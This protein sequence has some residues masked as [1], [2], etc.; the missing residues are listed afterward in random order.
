MKKL[1][2]IVTPCF[3]EED[4]IKELYLRICSAIEPYSDYD[5]EIIAI[6]NASTDSTVEV[7]KELAYN[8]KRLKIIVNTRNFGHIRSPYWG[9]LQSKGD[10]TIYLAS[11]LQD[12]PEY[13]SK[14]IEKWELGWK[15]VFAIK[16]IS[17]T[18][19]LMHGLRRLYYK[20]LDS[21]SEV[22]IVKDST[23]FGIYDRV[24]IDHIKKINDP[25]PYLRGMIAELGYPIS[26][27]EFNQPRR[28]RGISKNNF[29]TLYDIAMLG[30]ISHSVLPLRIAGMIGF[31]IATFSFLVSIFYFIYKLLNWNSFPLGLAPLVIFS[32]FL[33]GMLF[34]FLGIIGEYIGSI[35]LYL[36]NRPIVIE[37]ERVN[38]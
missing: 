5:F 35:H 3:N 37:K 24:V 9:I 17:Q 11:D 19:Q 30:I 13:I 10:A 21:I 7:L 32:T 23:G 6:D 36:K 18:N 26:T 14:F 34:V 31:S 22:P 29:Y 4:N 28:S 1:L 8:D 20:L 27:I 15:V 33:F 2:S 25:Y 12:P 16:P 38:F